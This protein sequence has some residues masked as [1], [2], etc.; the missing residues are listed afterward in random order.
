MF[1]VEAV[2]YAVHVQELVNE[3]LKGQRRNNELERLAHELEIKVLKQGS[4]QQPEREAQGSRC[5]HAP[6]YCEPLNQYVK[7]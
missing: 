3:K 5:K 2:T 1:N 6:I 4:V 7:R